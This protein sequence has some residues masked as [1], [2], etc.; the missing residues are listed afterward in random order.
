MSPM[1]VVSLDISSGF[2]KTL[3]PNIFIFLGGHHASL[4]P[5][6]AIKF[7]YV[8]A[9]CIGE[10]D[11]AVK[12]VAYKI[13]KNKPVRKITNT[14]IKLSD[15]IIEKNDR[16]PFEQNLDK[17]PFIDHEMWDKW[18]AYPDKYVSILINNNRLF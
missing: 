14:W 10:G 12:Q 7:P 1:A 2:P 3:D 11:E 18:I 9:I 4:A 8:D 15:G 16:V 6:H 5:D 17:L 13:S